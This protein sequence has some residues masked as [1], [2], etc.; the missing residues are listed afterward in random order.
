MP[1]N[2]YTMP[3]SWIQAFVFMKIFK[4]LEK[5]ANL[6]SFDATVILHKSCFRRYFDE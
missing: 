4:M 6:I 2:F 3:E 5:A 1:S